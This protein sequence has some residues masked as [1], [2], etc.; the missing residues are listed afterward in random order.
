MS[1]RHKIGLF[2]YKF[3]DTENYNF[4]VDNLLTFLINTGI[5]ILDTY[6]YFNKS[7]CYNL[8]KELGL[9]EINLKNLAEISYYIY[10]STINGYTG[11]EKRKRI[12]K[13]YSTFPIS[14][15]IYLVILIFLLSIYIH[16]ILCLHNIEIYFLEK[17][18]NFN[19][20]HFDNYIK[21]LNDIKK[22][23][24][25]DNNEEDDKGGDDM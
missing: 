13:N 14:L 1:E 6:T 10:N 12:N 22:K 20:T 15:M 2:V 9:N 25:N 18:I 24:R 21:N 17:L 3:N 7:E 19:S 16:Y 5:K 23:L 8:P 4:N 11:E